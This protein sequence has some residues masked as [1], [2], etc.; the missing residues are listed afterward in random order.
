MKEWH[1]NARFSTKLY[2]YCS[3]ASKTFT[4]TRKHVMLCYEW[5]KQNLVLQIREYLTEKGIVV[6]MDIMSNRSSDN[7]YEE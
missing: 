1:K 3:G 5:S 7:I 6:W 2:S 4:M